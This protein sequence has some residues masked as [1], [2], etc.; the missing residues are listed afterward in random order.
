MSYKKAPSIKHQEEKRAIIRAKKLEQERIDNFHR[1]MTPNQK[2][3]WDKT[4][5]NYYNLHSKNIKK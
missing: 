2:S 3:E 5:E 4:M 1:N